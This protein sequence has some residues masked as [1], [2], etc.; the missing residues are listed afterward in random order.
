MMYV[1]VQWLRRSSSRPRASLMM[2]S[3]NLYVLAS[4]CSRRPMCSMVLT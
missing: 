2:F 3:S 4:S 1:I